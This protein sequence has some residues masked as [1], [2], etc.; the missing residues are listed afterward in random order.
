[1]KC[2]R[3]CLLVL[4]LSTIL[5]TRTPTSAHSD[6]APFLTIAFINVG[7]GDS[8]FLQDHTGFDVLIDGGPSTAGGVV[9]EFIR[10]RVSGALDLI[11]VSH[12][13]SDHI[14]GL[15]Q[16]LQAADIP[17][18]SVL[19]SGYPGSTQTWNNFVSTVNQK[20]L[21]LTAIHSP[22]TLTWSSMTSYLIHPPQGLNNPSTNDSSLVF[23]VNFGANNL[24]FTGDIGFSVEN[25]LVNQNSITPSNVLKVAHHG[26]KYS[27]GDSFLAALQPKD[28]IIS[29]GT[30]PYG[31]P[32]LETL[33]R[34]QQVGSRIWRTDVWNTI[35]MHCT[36]IEC[37]VL[38]PE[39][40]THRVYLPGITR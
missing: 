36:L 10:S 16:V 30:N 40:F 18:A 6:V 33:D 12:P 28:A 27:S 26:S 35:F 2:F 20:G 24:L 8:A 1:M 14:G 37:R 15:I 11:I 9:T 22:A 4:L 7:Q 17:V 31:H 21:V 38:N 25:N 3:T 19:Y 13:D 23:R 32:S 29:V 34:L 39:F 5:L